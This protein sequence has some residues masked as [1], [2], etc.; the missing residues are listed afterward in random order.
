[1]RSP[2]ELPDGALR[3][4][5]TLT[6]TGV[7]VYR[8]AQGNETREY[9]PPEEVFDEVSLASFEG[10]VVT[11]DHPPV[12][13]NASNAATYKRGRLASVKRDGSNMVGTMIIEDEEL[14]KK[15]RAGKREVSHGY[16]CDL[17]MKSGVSP[18]G[19]KYDCIQRGIIGNHSAVVDA[20]RAGNAKAKMDRFARFDGAAEQVNDSSASKEP[21]GQNQTAAAAAHKEDRMDLAQALAALHAANEKIGSLTEKLGNETKRADAAVAAQKEAEAKV[22]TAEAKADSAEQRA[23]TAETKATEAETSVAKAKTDAA[24][25]AKTSVKARVVLITTAM[26]AGVPSVKRDGKDVEINDASDREVR[27]AVI[28]KIDGAEVPAD[29]RENDAYIEARFDIAKDRT[30]NT[31]VAF[32]ALNPIVNADA[33]HNTDTNEDKEEAARQKMRADSRNEY[34]KPLSMT[35][36]K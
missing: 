21:A 3:V 19:E 9:R 25:A 29:K 18:E 8:D 24:E 15:M 27:L 28:A 30:K 4:D 33:K 32:D 2:V 12:M 14:K 5:A 17:E 22:V 10:V 35:E 34:T 23:K 31:R 6:R 1:M 26:A 20:G 13:I 36:E 7:F 16:A 11:D